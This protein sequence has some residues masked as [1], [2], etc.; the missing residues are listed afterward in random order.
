M[1]VETN[2]MMFIN[3]GIV[4]FAILLLWS[5][6]KQGF[7]MKLVSILGFVVVGLLSWWISEPLSRVLALYPRGNVPLQ[8][9]I[10]ES[11]LY[12]HMNR[13]L[14]FVILFVLLHI[15]ILFLKPILKMISDIPVVSTINKA[16]GLVLGGIQ[17][18]LILFLVSLLFRLPMVPNGTAI[19]EST[20]LKHSEAA[21]NLLLFYAKEPL[22]QI[23]VVFDMMDQTKTLTKEEIAEIKRWLLSQNIEEEQVNAI[24][25][26]LRSE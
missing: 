26:S 18:V 20:L 22:Q 11:F 21:M 12:E 25:A 16:A 1:N 2:M 4:V 14:I 5:G 8:G 10:V 6:Y 13:L 24:V 15:V 17:A 19:V 7:L 23:S 3:L 9:T